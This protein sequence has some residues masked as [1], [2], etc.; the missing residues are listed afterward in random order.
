MSSWEIAIERALEN[1]IPKVDEIIAKYPYL[2]DM[3]ESLRKAKMEVL[4]NLE[5]YVRKTM[6]SVEETG[7]KAYLAK[8]VKEAQDILRRIIGN[9]KK[10]VMAK[11]NVAHEI[12]AI[13]ALESQGNDVSETD[14]GAYLI[15]LSGDT[16]SHIVFPSLH[17]TR[18]EVGKMLNRKGYSTISENS[19]HEEIVAAV[20]EMLRKKYVEA[21]VG[22][23]GAN[24]ISA[25]TGTVT[26]VEN[27]G[28]IRMVTVFPPIHVIITGID[29]IVPTLMDAVNEVIVQS[30]YAGLYPPTYVNITSG[31]SSTA[32][33]ELRRVSPATG[34]REVHVILVDNGRSAASRDP[35]MRDALLC[36]KCGRCYFACPVY[37]V[38]GKNWGRQPY[39]GPTGAMWTA[40]VNGDYQTANYCT[41]SGGCREVC[42]MKIDIPLVLEHIKWLSLKERS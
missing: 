39:G 27:E 25:D 7:G 31:P 29:K 9:K 33:I 34:P 5:Y 6:H 41:H 1:N 16:S 20:R 26:L 37:R 13:E 11:S 19:T 14:L 22:I 12:G 32:D 17:I 23:T 36:I 42:P 30:A 8:D 21:D 10:I 28:N 38:L 18:E 40:I 24:A 15:Q 2:K 35:E 3:A 4:D